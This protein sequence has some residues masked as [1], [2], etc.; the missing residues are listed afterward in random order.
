MAATAV[1]YIIKHLLFQIINC[2]YNFINILR[3]N[4]SRALNDF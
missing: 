2:K 1:K 4:V 3:H